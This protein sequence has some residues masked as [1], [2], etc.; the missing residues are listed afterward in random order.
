MEAKIQKIK[1]DML[2]AIRKVKAKMEE[3]DKVGLVYSLELQSYNEKV[4]LSESEINQYEL[5]DKD[6]MILAHLYFNANQRGNASILDM[7]DK[8]LDNIFSEFMCEQDL[9][10]LRM[11]T[12]DTEAK[13][14]GT[15]SNL[16]FMFKPK[17][18]LHFNET[19]VIFNNK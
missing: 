2:A 3:F 16:V 19:E 11:V 6:F 4:F 9:D 10:Y 12:E 8:T 5:D 14:E 18:E 7:D 1:R 13:G 15:G 17:T